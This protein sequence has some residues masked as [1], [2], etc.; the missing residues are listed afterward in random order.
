[1]SALPFLDQVLGRR[2]GPGLPIGVCQQVSMPVEIASQAHAA[3]DFPLLLHHE[4]RA[5]ATVTG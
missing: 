4:T 5:R 3:V 2:Q 1:M